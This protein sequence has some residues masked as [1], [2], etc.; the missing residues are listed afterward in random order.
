[1]FIA[2]RSHLPPL[3]PIRRRVRSALRHRRMPHP[4]L[5]HNERPRR[6]VGKRDE[7]A[8]KDL[9]FQSNESGVGLLGGF[10]SV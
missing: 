10:L 7:D 5:G 9:D 2:P 8:V 6:P 3:P 1:M 4:E